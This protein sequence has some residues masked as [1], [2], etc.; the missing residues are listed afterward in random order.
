MEFSEFRFTKAYRNGGGRYTVSPWA[1]VWA[2]ENYY[3]AAY[4][5]GE[6]ALRHFRVDK[7][8]E[9][10]AER[11]RRE[12]GELMDRFPPGTYS[13]SLFGMFGGEEL[14]VLLR[15][16]NQMAG[17]AADRF[18]RELFVMPDGPDHFL[19]HLTLTPSDQFFGWLAGLGGEAEIMAPAE[20]REQ[21]HRLCCRLAEDSGKVD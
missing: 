11:T 10:R 12:G 7:M 17:V 1:L 20:L 8:E 14:P 18:G 4:L 16:S 9:I 21:F 3:L 6:T 15:F 13:R 5:P 2:E 19:A